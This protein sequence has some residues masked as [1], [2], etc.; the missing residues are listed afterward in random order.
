MLTA[1]K[2]DNEPELQNAVRMLHS[3]GASAS[4]IKEE[5]KKLILAAN[6]G[7][8]SN[9]TNYQNCPVKI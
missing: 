8:D 3:S 4:R 1:I 7:A 9:D 6:P 2:S 5:A